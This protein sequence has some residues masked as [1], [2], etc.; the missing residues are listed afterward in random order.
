M[1]TKSQEE[2][3]RGE[4]VL[5]LLILPCLWTQDKHLSSPA[6]LAFSGGGNYRIG[7]NQGGK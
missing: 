4:E 6:I 1:E 3:Q 2:G 5:F 7:Q